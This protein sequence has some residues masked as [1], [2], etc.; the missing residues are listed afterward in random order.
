MPRKLLATVRL[1]T[2]TDGVATF[3]VAFAGKKPAQRYMLWLSLNAILEPGDRNPDVFAPVAWPGDGS[4][5]T[6]SVA[7]MPGVAAFVA[8]VSLF[9]DVW[10]PVSNEIELGS[11]R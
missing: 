6:V 10:T 9:P 3:T 7:L 11:E 2:V 8:Y 5:G 4:D 1:D